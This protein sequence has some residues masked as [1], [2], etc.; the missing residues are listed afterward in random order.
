MGKAA[1]TQQEFFCGRFSPH[2]RRFSAPASGDGW[3]HAWSEFRIAGLVLMVIGG[4]LRSDVHRAT[5]D[6][7]LTLRH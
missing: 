5:V 6:F 4:S 3:P 1:R 7:R 2:S